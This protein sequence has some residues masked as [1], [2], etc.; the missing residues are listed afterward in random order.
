MPDP[1][2]PAMT[3]AWWS[4]QVFAGR[5]EFPVIDLR[6][7]LEDELD[8]HHS[9]ASF[10]TRLRIQ[11]EMGHHD[12]QV[13]WM[14]CKPHAPILEA[15]QAMADWIDARRRQAARPD[16][17]ADTCFDEDGQIIAAGE[18]V[19]DGHWNGREDGACT[20]AYPPYSTSRIA[21][22]GDFAGDR[23]ACALKPVATALTDGTYGDEDLGAH[24]A[25]LEAIFPDGVC[26][27]DA[28]DGIRP[29]ALFPDG[30]ASYARS[31]AR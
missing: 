31:G 30:E 24:R 16:L 12:N 14:T 7:Y 3:A 23:F 6:H 22:G 18:G 4:G 9:V 10:Q 26:D 11:R 13:I 28:P 19:W 25:R 17:L 8:M 2:H 21:A 15:L 29:A 27:N 1:G 20:R 5:L